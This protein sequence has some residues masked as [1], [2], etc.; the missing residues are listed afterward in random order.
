[1]INITDWRT[2]TKVAGYKIKT[3]KSV[4]FLNTNNESSEREIKGIVPTTISHTH[5]HTHTHT[6]KE[7]TYL[8]R[9]R[10]AFHKL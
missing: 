8:G 3:Q 10:P 2:D 5:T 7:E 6:H 1:M 9:Q 4:V